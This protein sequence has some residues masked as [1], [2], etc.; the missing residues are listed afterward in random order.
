V[1]HTNPI[2]RAKSHGATFELRGAVHVAIL[3]G[4]RARKLPLAEF[5]APTQEEAAR[6]FLSYIGRKAQ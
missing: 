6:M 1:T 2:E 5:H 3:H 4:K